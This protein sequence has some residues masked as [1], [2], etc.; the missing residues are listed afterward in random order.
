MSDHM[1]TTAASV[2]T[3]SAEGLCER[4]TLR[5]RPVLLQVLGRQV[6]ENL[7]DRA[8]SVTRRCTVV[9]EAFSTVP[10]ARPRSAKP[11]IGTAAPEQPHN[12][13]VCGIVVGCGGIVVG[14]W[15]LSKCP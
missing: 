6:W 13:L 11:T 9:I 14:R 2:V 8:R 5:R 4:S 7:S 12:P 1:R 3:I 10:L 15:D